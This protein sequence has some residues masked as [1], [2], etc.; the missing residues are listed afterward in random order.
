LDTLPVSNEHQR[1]KIIKYIKEKRL[2]YPTFKLRFG[3]EADKM[4]ETVGLEP[5]FGQE[6]RKGVLLFQLP[7]PLAKFWRKGSEDKDDKGMD[8]QGTVIEWGK[9]YRSVTPVIWRTLD[10]YYES[11]GLDLDR[12]NAVGEH[13]PN[14]YYYVWLLDKS[15]P[16]KFPDWADVDEQDKY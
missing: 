5:R 14:R 3:R 13:D 8:M 11:E 1:E 16:P 7:K 15:R 9:I 2:D 6:P 4:L 10:E 12:I